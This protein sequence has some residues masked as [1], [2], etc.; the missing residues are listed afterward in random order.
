MHLPILLDLLISSNTSLEFAQV[1]NNDSL[2]P[3]ALHWMAVNRFG[4]LLLHPES[5]HKAPWP[6]VLARMTDAAEQSALFYFMQALAHQGML[7]G[8]TIG[9][10]R[11][12]EEA[13]E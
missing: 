1:V 11:R 12:A 10:K 4:R 6:L 8:N 7:S 3:E 5:V 2:S 9:R 13:G